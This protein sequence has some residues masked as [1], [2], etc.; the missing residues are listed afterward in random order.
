METVCT[1]A[2]GSFE[3][4]DRQAALCQLLQGKLS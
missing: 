4:I 2:I 3:A 1:Y